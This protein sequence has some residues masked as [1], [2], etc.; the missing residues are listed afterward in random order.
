MSALLQVLFTPITFRSSPDSL[1]SAPAAAQVSPAK[2]CASVVEQPAPEQLYLG[3]SG[4]P[5]YGS[6][7][8]LRRK[9]VAVDT[10]SPR[11]PTPLTLGSIE[12]QAAPDAAALAKKTA[13]LDPF[14]PEISAYVE[15]LIVF[16]TRVAK[17]AGQTLDHQWLEREEICSD[18]YEE[19][20]T[21]TLIH[22]FVVPNCES[23]QVLTALTERFPRGCHIK[24]ASE[25][26]RDLR[27]MLHAV[28]TVTVGSRL[29]MW[30]HGAGLSMLEPVYSLAT[31]Q[32]PAVRTS[33]GWRTNVPAWQSR[34]GDPSQAVDFEGRK[35]DLLALMFGDAEVI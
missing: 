23:R 1:S 31:L 32:L 15:A 33:A 29:R 16:M 12:K 10:P 34:S 4:I 20:T 30:L 13:G 14:N 9:P 11:C 24:V 6:F 17:H 26:A 28:D 25:N 7:G 19:T 3:V 22:K 18:L 2:P 5:N 35:A 21:T 27:V 8:T